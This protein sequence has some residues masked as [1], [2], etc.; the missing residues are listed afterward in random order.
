L[1]AGITSQYRPNEICRSVGTSLRLRIFSRSDSHPE[2]K[3]RTLNIL[4]WG[5]I[6]NWAKDPKIAY[7]TIN[8][9]A[10]TVDTASSYR[11]A[12]M[13]RRC[14][15]PVDG[16]YE[17]KKVPSGKIPVLDRYEGQFSIRVCRVVGRLQRPRERRMAAYLHDHHR[18]TK[19]V[20]A[21]DPHPH[22]GHPTGRASQCLVVR[23]SWKRDLGSLPGRPNEGVAD[24]FSCKIVQKTMTLNS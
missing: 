18:R 17:R 12:F 4:R 2:T 14:L 6:P 1:L 9:R 19:R 13:K 3:Q 15:I 20:C 10:E 23:R 21:R 5:L 11:Q 16:F 7:K 8:A 24:Q 22:A